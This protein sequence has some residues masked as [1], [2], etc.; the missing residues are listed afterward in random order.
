MWPCDEGLCQNLVSDHWLKA[1]ALSCLIATGF[2]GRDIYNFSFVSR[3]QETMWLKFYS[4]GGDPLLEVTILSRLVAMGVMDVEIYHFSF[5]N[6]PDH[7]I[8]EIKWL[9]RWWLLILGKHPVNF[10]SCGHRQCGDTLLFS[11]TTSHNHMAKW[12]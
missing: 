8:K 11:C 10:C 9:C 7:Q 6:S 12:M 4:L 3:P 1:T 2:V 5:V